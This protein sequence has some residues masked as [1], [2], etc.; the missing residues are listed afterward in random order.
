M[1]FPVPLVQMYQFLACERHGH[2][3]E[4]WGRFYFDRKFNQWMKKSELIQVFI[5]SVVMLGGGI[6]MHITDTVLRIKLLKITIPYVPEVLMVFGALGLIA[7][8][9]ELI[10]SIRGKP[11]Q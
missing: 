9:V 6:F 7:M 2:M 3:Y 1:P 10:S 4:F 5:G 11:K 8:I